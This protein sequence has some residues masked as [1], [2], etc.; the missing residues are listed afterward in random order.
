MSPDPS[1]CD[2]RSA[3]PARRAEP[4][5]RM[6]QT[7]FGTL[8][9]GEEVALCTLAN[10]NGVTCKVMSYGAAITHLHVPGRDGRHADVV[11]GY[12]RLEDYLKGDAYIGATI[13]RVANR[14]AASRFT[15]DQRVYTL[16]A[17]DGPHHLH[18]GRIG[19]DKVVWKIAAPSANAGAKVS[20]THCSRDGEEGYPGTLQAR[21]SYT[22]TDQDEILLDYEATADRPTPV[23]LTNHT[24]FNLG[25]RGTVLDHLLELNANR[26]TPLDQCH[27]PTGEIAPVEGTAAD[28]RRATRIGARLEQMTNGYSGLNFNYVLNEP[29]P[30]PRFAARLYQPDSGRTLELWT[31]QPGIQLYSAAYMRGVPMG[32]YGATYGPS[33][34]VCLEPQHFPNAVNQPGFPPVILRPGQKYQ[35]KTV[36]RF[37]V[38]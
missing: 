3:P 15:L 23:N 2:N 33:S 18:G 10:K 24:Y 20:F 17:N 34:G 11:L 30:A 36:W 4:G 31:T 32:K 29:G 5:E 26:H 9:T 13:G 37:F 28:F 7:P 19:F 8:P 16:A 22:L 6:R 14:I 1:L 21:V 38:A 35:Q 27:I 25:G 12:P